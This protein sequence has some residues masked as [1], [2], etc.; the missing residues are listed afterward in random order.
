MNVHLIKSPEYNSND[1]QSVY[2]LLSTFDGPLTFSVADIEFSVE[3]F[4]TFGTFYHRGNIDPDLKK[5][6]IHNSLKNPWSWDRFFSICQ[7]YRD[8]L[9]M[10]NS[11]FV[12]FLTERKNDM[13]WFGAFDENNNAFIQTSDWNLYTSNNPKYPIAYEV[14]ANVL[15]KLMT[16]PEKPVFMNWDPGVMMCIQMKLPPGLS[17][18]FFHR[19]PKGCINDL[20]QEKRQIIL[21]LQTGNICKDCID[22]LKSNKINPALLIQAKTIFN[23]IRTEFLFQTEDPVLEPIPLIVD[24][25][26]KIFFP[27]QN[28]EIRLNPIFKT[29]YLFF[30]SKPD[31]VTLAQLSDFTEELISIYRKIRPSASL[32]D[33]EARIKNLCYPNG[34]GFNPAKS[35]INKMITEILRDPLADFY[36]I[37]GERGEPYKIT[38]PRNLVD[39]RY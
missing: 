35:R 5:K 22:Q 25:R 7:A 23:A 11:D 16:I 28:I 34:D 24:K 38:V 18:K 29:L 33:S 32:E 2:E 31:G 19:I 8:R 4:E 39:I 21:K 15:R 13:N 9:N 1:F 27:D 6:M 14:V 26:N 37:S 36:R 12:I 17:E 30:L 20:C 10:Q 3:E